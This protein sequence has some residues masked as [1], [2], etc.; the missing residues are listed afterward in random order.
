MEGQ[1]TRMAEVDHMVW[2]TEGETVGDYVNNK[3]YTFYNEYIKVGNETLLERA[4]LKRWFVV[5]YFVY[6][7]SVLVELV[8]IVRPLVNNKNS[9][10]DLDFFN[11]LLY[12]TFDLFAFFV[13]YFM[14][15][16]LNEVHHQYY[17]KM[18]TLY[19]KV[20]IKLSDERTLN[21]EPGKI[22]NDNTPEEKK[23]LTEFYCTAMEKKMDKKLDFDFVPV[24]IGISIP[25]DN[26]GYSFTILISIMSIIF[27]FTAV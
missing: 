18:A 14:G 1:L 20:D 21:F 12:L 25:L 26:P 11:T 13:P 9:K 7:L 15:I 10:Y 3:F 23:Q 8:H 5:Q 27:N 2:N 17:E 6:L 22:T 4:A 24:I 16:W 19:Y